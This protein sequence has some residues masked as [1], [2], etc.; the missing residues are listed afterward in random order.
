MRQEAPQTRQN[1]TYRTAETVQT[2][3][4]SSD[5]R[6]HD[7]RAFDAFERTLDGCRIIP[8]TVNQF[9]ALFRPA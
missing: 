6:Q 2:N 1:D 8:I 5:S 7:K 4:A 9:H 3:G